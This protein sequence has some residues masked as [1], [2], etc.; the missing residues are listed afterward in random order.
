MSLPALFSSATGGRR[1]PV[2]SE[3]SVTED[4]DVRSEQ[5]KEKL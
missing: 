2:F 5:R 1:A 3:V 4:E